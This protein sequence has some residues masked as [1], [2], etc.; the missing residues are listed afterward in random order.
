[1]TRRKS[2]LAPLALVLL[3]KGRLQALRPIGC[4]PWRGSADPEAG[5]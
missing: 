3:G 2:K 4:A 1:V 5:K